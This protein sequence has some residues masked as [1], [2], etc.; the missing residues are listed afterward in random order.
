MVKLIPTNVNKLH[1][2]I[3]EADTNI[4]GSIIPLP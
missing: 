1:S 2:S 4:A 3:S